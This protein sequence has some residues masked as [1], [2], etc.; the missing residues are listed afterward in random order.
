MT[1]FKNSAVKSMVVMRKAFHTIDSRVSTTFRDFD[2]TPAQFSVLD[3]L[4]S[5]GS[6]RIGELVSSILTTSGNMTIVIKNMEKSGWIRREA[7][8]RDGRAYII[9]LTKKGRRIIERALPAHI[10]A[11]EETFSILTQEEQEQL[12]TL[13]KKF[14]TLDQNDK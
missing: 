5:K 7:S 12:I 1:K 8:K 9:H 14:K 3:V 4:Y 6:M 11:V 13:L 10:E 2:L